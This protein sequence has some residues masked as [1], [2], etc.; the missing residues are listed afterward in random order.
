MITPFQKLPIIILALL[1]LLPYQ[2]TI[3]AG[4]IEIKS[5]KLSNSGNYRYKAEGTM[6][7]QLSKSLQKALT[8]GVKLR[9]NID[10]TLG[11]HRDWW[12]NSARHISRISYQLNYHALSKHYILKRLDKEQ[13]WSF[14][15]LP[16]A[17]KQIGKIENHLLPP[18]NANIENGKY[19]IYVAANLTTE[20]M[21]LPLKIQSYFKSNKYLI[22][23]EGVLWALP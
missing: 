10:F 17:L 1:L 9:A 15:T 18:L 21:S 2:T 23:S 12:W 14:S 20:T 3:A 19:Y 6:S 22:E 4:N 8:H 11:K 16:A 5:L 13:H 7:I